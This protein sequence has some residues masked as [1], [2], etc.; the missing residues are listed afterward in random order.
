MP[1]KPQATACGLANRVYSGLGRLSGGSFPPLFAIELCLS[2]LLLE[3]LFPENKPGSVVQ[4]P[5]Q[6]FALSEMA[7]YNACRSAYFVQL[8]S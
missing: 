3:G 4:L 2:P 6:M 1:A 8:C 7:A 5:A